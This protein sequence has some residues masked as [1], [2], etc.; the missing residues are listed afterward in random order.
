[1][2]QAKYHNPSLGDPWKNLSFLTNQNMEIVLR[3]LGHLN[4]V[5]YYVFLLKALYL[6]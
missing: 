3:M 1:M 4:I 5:K 6:I 2:F